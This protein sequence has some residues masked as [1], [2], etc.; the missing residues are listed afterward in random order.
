VYYTCDALE[1]I[2]Y[3]GL[4]WKEWHEFYPERVESSPFYE[5][6]LAVG[7]RQGKESVQ[8]EILRVLGL[9]KGI[10]C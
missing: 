9:E 4:N 8:E 7:I 6:G 2:D 10:F 1:V 3:I 5:A